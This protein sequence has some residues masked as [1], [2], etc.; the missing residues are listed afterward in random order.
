MP[1]CRL[2]PL[3]GSPSISTRPRVAVS[4]PPTMRMSVVLPQPD[5]P[6]KTTSSP[7]SIAMETSSMTA[8]GGVLGSAW[9]VLL[10]R[11]MAMKGCTASAQIGEP[12]AVQPTDCLVADQADDTDRQN[13]AVD[14][15]AL[16]VAFGRHDHVADARAGGDDLGDDQIGPAP[17]ERDAQVVDHAGQHRRQNDVA[18]HGAGLGAHGHADLDIF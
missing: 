5:G 3:T 2:G 10:T 12:A 15:V 16:H 9:N 14:D 17:A 18:Q 8:I 11:S 13:A 7:F 1:F 6:R 4:R